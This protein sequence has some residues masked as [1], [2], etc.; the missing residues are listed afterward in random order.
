[1]LAAVKRIPAGHRAVI[2]L[3]ISV[4]GLFLV[5]EAMSPGFFS[6]AHSVN[7]FRSAAFVGMA[8]IGQTL[9]VLTGGIDLSVGSLLSLGNV[10]ACLLIDGK[11]ENNVWAIALI[12]FIGL[13]VGLC[14]GI[15]V[16]I[17]DISPMV[18][19]MAMGVIV[20]G[21]TL[22]WSKGAPK[23]FASPFL[24]GIGAGYFM[25]MPVSALLWLALSLATLALLKL[26]VPGR[27]IYYL[28]ANEVASVFAGI[29][30]AIIKTAVYAISGLAAVLTGIIYAGY[31]SVAFLDIGKDFTMSSVTAVV[32]GGTAM[33][34]GRG[35]YGGTMAG[36]TLLCLIDSIMTIMNIQEA[37]KKIMT[38]LVIIVLIVVYYRKNASAR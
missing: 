37:G 9:V 30:V 18:M 20:T 31:T 10:L 34:G 35:G 38:G 12:L 28:G 22:I 33:T 23:G 24:H 2:V 13:A 8:A 25:G 21:V 14:S 4:L 5:G 27:G 11:D 7:I 16:A 29:N 36:A 15:G 6:I 26:T 17:L 19:T 1:M 3:W 32:I